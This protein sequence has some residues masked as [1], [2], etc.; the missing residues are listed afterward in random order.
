MSPGYQVFYPKHMAGQTSIENGKKG[1]RKK[2][3]KATHTLDAEQV[4]KLYIEKAREYALP[5]L[6]ALV[7][8]AR[9]GDVP[10]IKEFNDRAFGKAPQAITGPEGGN[11][12]IQFS[13][14]FN[15]DAPT[16]PETSK[17]N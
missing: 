14:L 15:K 7:R 6:Q 13:Q 1:G 12:V 3:S 8:K 11:L 2:G 16:P 4:K 5:I 10:A 17:D 9:K